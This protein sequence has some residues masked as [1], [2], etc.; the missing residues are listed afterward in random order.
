LHAHHRTAYSEGGPTVT[1]N[2][3]PLCSEHHVLTH[4]Q[5]TAADKQAG[6]AQAH[7]PH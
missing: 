4:Q 7:L 5:Q 1:R 2:L 3:T 6:R